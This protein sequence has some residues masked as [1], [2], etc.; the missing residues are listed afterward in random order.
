MEKKK[1][2]SPYIFTT[3]ETVPPEKNPEVQAII[4][5]AEKELEKAKLKKSK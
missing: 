3:E 4:R 5:E 2:G 1:T